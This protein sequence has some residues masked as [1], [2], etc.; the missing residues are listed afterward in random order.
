[1]TFA[2]ALLG[3]R[4]DAGEALQT[5]TARIAFALGTKTGQKS[6]CQDRSSA[7]KLGEDFPIWMGGED[8]P[9]L[10][11]KILNGAHHQFEFLADELDTTDEHVNERGFIG[12]GNRLGDQLHA[13][14]QQRNAPRP[15]VV[16]ELADQS[17][18]RFLD[19]LKARPFEQEMGGHGAP[20][21]IATKVQGLGKVLLENGLETVGEA[22]SF[23][24]N[25]TTVTDPLLKLPGE[26]VFGMPGG[27][28]VMVDQEQLG[29]M[30]GILGVVFGSA[31]DKGLAVLEQGQWING[32][33][34]D[35]G[36]GLQEE[37]DVGGGLFNTDG[38]ATLG[39]SGAE[40][41]EP[42]VQAFRAGAEGEAFGGA[43]V[44]VD[45]AEISLGVGSVGANDQIEGMVDFH[46]GPLARVAI[47]RGLTPGD[48]NIESPE[49]NRTPSGEVVQRVKPRRQAG[50]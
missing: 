14:I 13:P 9:D 33:E 24:N 38:D 20:E 42:G 47:P 18:T 43:G 7:G 11:V 4:R 41:G 12:Q 19:G 44:G 3:H 46:G 35:P 28:L 37:D 36:I 34:G 40:L 22:G 8:L 6:G 25:R 26:G 15:V 31:G 5:R 29:Q 2:S 1:M 23:I 17:G 10:I 32:E 50:R 48:G 45:Q 21:F 49:V 27:E 30:I 16:V 39:V